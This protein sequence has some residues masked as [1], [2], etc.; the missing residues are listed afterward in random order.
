MKWYKLLLIIFFIC[1]VSACSS[2][3]SISATNTPQP[4]IASTQPPPVTGRIFFDMNGSGLQD[5]SS[6]VFDPERLDDNRQ[7]LQP[8]L[9]KAIKEYISTHADLKK[10]DLVTLSEPV[11]SGYK[12]CIDQECATTTSDGSFSIPNKTGNTTALLNITDPNANKPALAMRYINEWKGAKTISAYE[13]DGL[14]IPEQH[15]NFT[16]SNSIQSGLSFSAAKVIKIGLMQGLYTL[17]FNTKENFLLFGFFDTDNS[18]NIHNYLGSQT[19]FNPG[20]T[21]GTEDGHPGIDFK[22]SSSNLLYAFAPGIINNGDNGRGALW[23][24]ISGNKVNA[25]VGHISKYLLVGQTEVYRGMIIALSGSSGTGWPHVHMQ[26]GDGIDF[27]RDL[28]TKNSISY[29][30]VDNLPQFPSN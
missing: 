4:T 3:K 7:P 14:K 10:G 21:I 20:Q 15:L 6:F 24:A 8:D 29:W 18:K 16:I 23:V 9:D 5:E 26:I 27:F 30:T 2:N 1:I 12:V 13:M 28:Y 11:L 17:P 22:I 19:R 25:H